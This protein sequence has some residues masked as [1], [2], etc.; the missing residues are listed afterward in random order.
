MEKEQAD[1]I[2]GGAIEK[3][4]TDY[5]LGGEVETHQGWSHTRTKDPTRDSAQDMQAPGG[6]LW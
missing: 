3:E 1:Y 2:L 4:Q 5:I 6:T